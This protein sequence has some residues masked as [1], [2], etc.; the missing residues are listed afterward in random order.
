M[1][2]D[3]KKYLDLEGLKSYDAKIK[4][5][6]NT[7]DTT[8]SN[9][10]DKVSGDLAAEVANRENGDK[11]INDKIGTLPEG[12]TVAQAIEDAANAAGKANEDL[13]KR[14]AANEEAIADINDENTG[15]LKQAKDHADAKVKAEEDRAV[16]KENELAKAISDEV[17]RATKA[18]QD[19]QDAIDAHEEFVDAKLTTLIGEDT[20]KSVRKIANEELAA[21]LLSG[22]ADADF[23]TLQELAAWLEDHPEDVAEINLNIQNLQTLIGE[24]PE[25]ATATDI[26]GYIAEA[27]AA[28]KSRA[29]GIEGGLDT[30][31]Q[32]VEAAVGEGGSVA[33]QIANA[34][35]ELDADVKSAEVEAGKG[36]QVQVVE[37]D[38][39][40]TNVALTGNFDNS[41]DAKGAAAAAQ[42][43]AEATAAADATSKANAAQAAAEATAAADATAKANAAQAAA[44]ATAATKAADAQAA[45][46]DYTDALEDSFVKI[47]TTEI[48]NL[49]A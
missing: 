2:F 35:A 47:T 9:A 25:D 19:L 7:A 4:N 30:R 34:I 3:E 1:A 39:K 40:I 48:N 29:E 32:A 5:L 49:F 8:L 17:D 10:I 28:E 15:I 46:A 44:E 20:G 13:E 18:E 42:A 11:A 41:Y 24:L 43:A 27:V 31:L 36:L 12:K 6:I 26:V 23:K 21:Q 33:T 16:A 45:A 37:V 38:G 22:D 14:V